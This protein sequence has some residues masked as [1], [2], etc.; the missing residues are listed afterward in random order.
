[1]TSLCKLVLFIIV[2]GCDSGGSTGGGGRED[3]DP[4]LIAPI[5]FASRR[6]GA[7]FGE[8]S[9]LFGLMDGGGGAGKISPLVARSSGGT[10]VT[11]GAAGAVDGVTGAGGG[12]GRD[13]RKPAPRLQ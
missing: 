6:G 7:T 1:M 9:S 5:D 3:N 11:A 13:A 2:I 8:G 10:A 4:A 12:G